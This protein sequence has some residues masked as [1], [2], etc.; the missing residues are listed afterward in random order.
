MRS[1]MTAMQTSDVI[2]FT[3]AI[4]MLGISRSTAERMIRDPRSDIPR[5]FK[6]RRRRYCRLADIEAYV[7]RKAAAAQ[8]RAQCDPLASLAVEP[9]P[10]LHSI[11][12]MPSAEAEITRR[13]TQ[14]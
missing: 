4:Q 2:P 12:V 10:F 3:A 6:Q 7:A 8:V 11:L 13:L 5:P 14:N 9:S 1:Q